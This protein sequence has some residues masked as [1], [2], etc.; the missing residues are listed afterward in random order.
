VTSISIPDFNSTI[1]ALLWN[2]F[3]RIVLLKVE[4]SDYDFMRPVMRALSRYKPTQL[5]YVEFLAHDPHPTDTLNPLPMPTVARPTQMILD[6]VLPL[7]SSTAQYEHLTKLVL[8]Y[9][10]EGLNLGAVTG[11]PASRRSAGRHPAHRCLLQQLGEWNRCCS[12]QRPE[13]PLG[14]Q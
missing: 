14:V 2:E 3:H 9:M 13:I 7:W 11:C 4:A 1:L 6:G 8:A 10:D 12:N 5:R